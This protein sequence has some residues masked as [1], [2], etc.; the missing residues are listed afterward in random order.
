MIN[1]HSS[2]MIY[3]LINIISFEFRFWIFF[4]YNWC[5]WLMQQDGTWTCG[6]QSRWQYTTIIRLSFWDKVHCAKSVTCL[7]Q[8]VLA[9]WN[10]TG[11]APKSKQS[12]SKDTQGVMS[13]LYYMAKV[14]HKF[15]L[16]SSILLSLLF[17]TKQFIIQLKFFKN[18]HKKYKYQVTKTTCVFIFQ[19]YGKFW[20]ILL[21]HF[22]K[23]FLKILEL[24]YLNYYLQYPLTK[25][26]FYCESDDN[27][28][29]QIIVNY[30]SGKD[31][32]AYFHG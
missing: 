4:V 2:L 19:K 25:S 12:S 28:N 14:T 21:E 23:T 11:R 20:N 10:V 27:K 6:H 32:M 18:I 9:C 13:S 15:I 26:T 24:I 1:D 22:L 30:R 17:W 7:L 16:S 5:N 3:P 31:F 29:V 8:M